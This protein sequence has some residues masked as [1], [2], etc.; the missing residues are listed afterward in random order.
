MTKSIALLPL[1]AAALSV[2]AQAQEVSASVGYSDLDL[3]SE[4]GVTRL[5]RRIDAAIEGVCG[6]HRDQRQLSAALTVRK[7]GRESWADV[8]GPRQTA[9][10]RANGKQPSVEVVDARMP[11]AQAMTIR[12][13]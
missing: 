7:C 11:R 5:D 6:D 8:Q 3:T 1:L 12:R 4:A 2:S 10:E 13:R 9:I